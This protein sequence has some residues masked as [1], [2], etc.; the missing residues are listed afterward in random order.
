MI[1]NM[2]LVQPQ[3]LALPIE[4]RQKL[5]YIFNIP[6]SEG[7][8]VV[9]GRVV[10]DGHTHRDLAYI[11]IPAMQEY[12]TSTS[13]DFLSLFEEVVTK[14]QTEIRQEQLPVQNVVPEPITL[15]VGEK[16][17]LATEVPTIETPSGFMVPPIV[18]AKKKGGR[19]KKVK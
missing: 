19:P 16:T 9:D 4:V 8:N 2:Q 14:I 3:W 11:T 5:K 1:P 18:E 13:D 10:S 15:K 12:V 7:T 17:F 6:R